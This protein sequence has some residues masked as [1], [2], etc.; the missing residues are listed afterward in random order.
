MAILK[1]PTGSQPWEQTPL[2]VAPKP[3]RSVS[4]ELVIFLELNTKRGK[5]DHCPKIYKRL[6]L[7]DPP[8]FTQIWIFWLENIPSGSPV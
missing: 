5:K 3:C 8:K 4:A 2:L 1:L 7:Q 6:P